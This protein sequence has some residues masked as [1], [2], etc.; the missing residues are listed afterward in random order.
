LASPL[1]PDV[2]AC[3]YELVAEKD[4]AAVGHFQLTIPV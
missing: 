1:Q 4:Y 2:L 3:R